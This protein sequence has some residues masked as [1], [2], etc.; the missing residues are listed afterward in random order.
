[1]LSTFLKNRD[2]FGHQVA[3][4]IKGGNGSEQTSKLG[5]FITLLIYTFIA[6]YVGIKMSKMLSGSLDNITVSQQLIDYKSVQNVYFEDLIP[7]VGIA[8][9]GSSDIAKYL[10]INIYQMDKNQYKPAAQF[11][12]CNQ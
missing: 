3:F 11:H 1:M 12:Q 5:G 9:F 10:E 6:T 8:S 7:V 4:T 2:A